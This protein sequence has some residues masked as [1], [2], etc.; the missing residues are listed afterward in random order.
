MREWTD[1][2]TTRKPHPRRDDEA[3][4]WRVLAT[5]FLLTPCAQWHRSNLILGY[6]QSQNIQRSDVRPCATAIWQK[7]KKARF[8]ISKAGSEFAV[9]RLEKW[10]LRSRCF[11]YCQFLQA[12]TGQSPRFFA[13]QTSGVAGKHNAWAWVRDVLFWLFAATLL[14]GLIYKLSHRFSKW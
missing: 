14:L 1:R 2:D 8:S 9:E 3:F 4:R 13:H 7:R 5:L 6:C 11:S 12:G 10:C